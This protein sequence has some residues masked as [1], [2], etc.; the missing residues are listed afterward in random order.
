[1]DKL[2]IQKIFQS[3]LI[4]IIIGILLVAS[5]VALIE[6]F[7]QLVL[8]KSSLTD[9]IKNIIVAAI[10]I[11]LAL[12][13]YIFL[14]RGIEKRKIIELSTSSFWLNAVRGILTGIILQGLIILVMY[15][16]DGYKIL[17]VNPLSYILP[18]LISSLVAGFVAEILI[19]GIFFRI[20][21]QEL[22]TV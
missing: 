21:E 11:S 15:I 1:M 13:T 18:A 19:R 20:V 22:G 16:F 9:D 8:D 12:I 10:Q 6:F 5:V 14:F 2:T 7:R 3:P 17:L 4:K